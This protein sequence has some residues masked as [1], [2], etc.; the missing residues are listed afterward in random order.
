MCHGIYNH[1]RKGHKI[2]LDLQQPFV[3]YAKCCSMLALN[4]Q[5][6]RIRR[7]DHL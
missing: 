2:D 6:S 5:R 1:V 3:D 7:D 4:T